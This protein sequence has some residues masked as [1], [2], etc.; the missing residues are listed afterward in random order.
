MWGFRVYPE[1]LGFRAYPEGP[2]TR[3]LGTWV[4]GNSSRNILFVVVCLI[5][6]Y[7]DPQG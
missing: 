3:E 4:V 5:I 7:L 6:W 2:S 1:G